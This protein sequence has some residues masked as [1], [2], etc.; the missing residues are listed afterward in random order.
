MRSFLPH[1]KRAVRAFLVSANL[2]LPPVRSLSIACII[3]V[4]YSTG[5]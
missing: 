3:I 2:T 1:R 5:R 4:T